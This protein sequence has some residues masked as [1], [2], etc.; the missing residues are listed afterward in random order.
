MAGLPVYVGVAEAKA[1]LVTVISD[2]ETVTDLES[3]F[4]GTAAV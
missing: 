2:G 4:L 1:E 3:L